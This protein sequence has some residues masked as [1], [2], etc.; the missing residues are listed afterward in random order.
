MEL[1]KTKVSNAVKEFEA[2]FCD[3]ICRATDVT[4]F[5]PSMTR[6]RGCEF[7][8]IFAEKFSKKIGV[9]DSKQS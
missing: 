6:D 9:F 4:T 5:C 2:L 1:C 3:S 8:N 7:L